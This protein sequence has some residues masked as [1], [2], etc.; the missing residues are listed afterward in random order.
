MLGEMRCLAFA[1]FVVACSGSTSQ[2][3]IGP[4]PERVT[5]GPLAGGT[6]HD[7]QCT[8][9]KNFDEVGPA[10]GNRKR[11][12]FRLSSAQELWVTLP[13][14]QLYKSPERAEACFYVDFMP[15]EYPVA[16]RASNKDGVSAQLEIF[17]LGAKAKTRYST[18]KFACGHPG[19]CAFED[20]D[21][22]KVS[23]KEFHRGLHDACG[24][25]KIK[26]INWDHGK[27]PDGTHPSEL[28]VRLTLDIYKFM[29]E[30]PS[31]DSTCGAGE[32]ARSK[33]EAA[34]PAPEE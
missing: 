14:H 13:D 30:K 25:T 22:A 27:A 15:G 31:G 17:E 33:Q 2:I 32:G 1:L 4:P 9:A 7:D 34:E 5:R 3:K 23:F 21:A 29:P 26:N 8:C 6:C 10:E 28:L 16:L 20:L 18:F 24:S 19:V 11:Y 12:E